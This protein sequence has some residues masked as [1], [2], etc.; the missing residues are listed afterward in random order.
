M[1][2]FM[3]EFVLRLFT[4]FLTLSFSFTN[5]HGQTDQEDQISQAE[6]EKQMKELEDSLRWKT[7]SIN[8]HNNLATL[9]VPKGFRYINHEDAVKVLS[10][11]G[12]E[13]IGD[14][15]GMLFPENVSVF[16]QNSWAVVIE[17]EDSGYVSDADAKSINYDELLV[18]MQ[19]G[20]AEENKER[21][22]H[23]I[24]QIE[25]IG[26]A[27]PPRY[28][29]ST[30]KMFW[31][32]EL[33]F[34]GMDTHSLNY[35]IRMLGREGI[36]ILTIVSEMSQ[37]KSIEPSMPAIISSTNFN[38]GNTYGDYKEGTDRKSDYGL[39]ELVVG[40]AVLGAAAKTGLLKGLLA[41]IFAMKKFIIVGFVALLGF[42]RKYWGRKEKKIESEPKESTDN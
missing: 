22:K 29:A 20:I 13:E 2:D 26:W 8:L 11:W 34:E 23:D 41:G 18:Q 16:D 7:G 19:K 42:V 27:K 17:Y 35:N 30:K 21:K 39:A 9:V 40:G 3:I 15:L 14:T 12:N 38:A 5:V 37:L 24:Q 25:L 36:L 32:K 31:A 10:A 28:D 6:I 1:G 33:H 4:V